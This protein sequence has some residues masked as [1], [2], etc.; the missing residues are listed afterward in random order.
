MEKKI[1]L[2][3]ISKNEIEGLKFIGERVNSQKKYLNEIILVDGQSTDGTIE[4]AKEL[5]WNVIVQSDKEMGIMNGIRIGIENSN[6]EYVTMFTPDN[7]CIPEKIE[8]IHNVLSENVTCDM[9]TVSRYYKDAKSY[10]DDY[11]SGIFHEI[12][13]LVDPKKIHLAQAVVPRRTNAL[14][15]D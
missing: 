5:G 13:Y 15:G 9:V 6:S 11:F 3:I 7:N 14:F 1:S 4:Y 2:I 10:D 8:E 12:H